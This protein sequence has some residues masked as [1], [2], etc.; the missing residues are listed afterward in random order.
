VSEEIHAT[1]YEPS[2]AL[3]TLNT[4]RPGRRHG[5]TTF[6]EDGQNVDNVFA[7]RREWRHKT[8]I[9]LTQGHANV[10]SLQGA[11]VIAPITAL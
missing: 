2:R 10:S 4:V 5:C 6:V 8:G 7:Q 3:F 11:T 9:A 1:G